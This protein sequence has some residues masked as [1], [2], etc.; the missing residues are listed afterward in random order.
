MANA[1]SR[2]VE[3]VFL[4]VLWIGAA[5]PATEPASN[6]QAIS[7]NAIPQDKWINLVVAVHYAPE[8]KGEPAKVAAELLRTKYTFFSQRLDA[9]STPGKPMLFFEAVDMKAAGVEPPSL[10]LL[11]YFG[12]DITKPQADALQKSN[13]ALFLEFS[14]SGRDALKA[15]AELSRLAGEVAQRTNGLIWDDETRELFSVNEWTK[16]RINSWSDGVPWVS[17]HTTIH[18]Y[19]DTDYVRAISL[20]MRKFGYPDVVVSEFSWG[21]KNQINTLMNLL[22]QAMVE[23]A[24]IPKQTPYLL[25]A[26][27]IKHAQERKSIIESIIEKGTGNADVVLKDAEPQDGDPTNRLLEVSFERYPGKTIHERQEQLISTAFGFKDSSQ[28]V[29]HTDEILAARARAQKKFETFRPR[30][31]KGLAPGERLLVKAGFDAVDGRKE[32]MWVEVNTWKG[33]DIT[34]LLRNEPDFIPT[35]HAGATVKVKQAEIFDYINY[36]PDGSS[37]GNE[38]GVLMSKQRP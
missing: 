34:G 11:Q 17:K 8:P 23:G 3:V 36:K 12:R 30:F 20:G 35:L 24:P 7:Q 14:Y 29:K 10:Q 33:G 31:E 1:R 15:V 37:E 16:S 25:K 6:T 26:T 19:K 22:S 21:I 38:T 32:W 13:K 9:T 18:A 28:D 27:A 5:L 2:L 4:F